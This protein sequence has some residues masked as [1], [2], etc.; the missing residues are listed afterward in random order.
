LINVILPRICGVVK[1]LSTL[2]TKSEPEALVAPNLLQHDFH[3]DQP[4]PNWVT[5]RTA[6]GWLYQAVVLDLFLRMGEG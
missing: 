2:L 5:D 1:A 3:A 4:D 6:E